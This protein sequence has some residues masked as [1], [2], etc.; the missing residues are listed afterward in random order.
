MAPRLKKFNYKWKIIYAWIDSMPEDIHRAYCKV[1]KRDFSIGGRGENKVK[2]HQASRD[3]Q[4][5]L[6]NSKSSMRRFFQS[7]F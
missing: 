3:H 5:A 6:E 1:C 7:M 4:I 2:D